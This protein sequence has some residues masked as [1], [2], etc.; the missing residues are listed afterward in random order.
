MAITTS[1]STSVKPAVFNPCL[2]VPPYFSKLARSLLGWLRP[3]N[4]DAGHT[5][6]APEPQR[7]RH[8]TAS[9]PRSAAAYRAAGGLRAYNH[10]RWSRPRLR[11]DQRSEVSRD[12]G[13][14]WH[15]DSGG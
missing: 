14:G 10:R 3:I 4:W 9:A 6:S 11:G 2:M 15:A 5:G 12:C 13:L 1:S 7:A 8:A